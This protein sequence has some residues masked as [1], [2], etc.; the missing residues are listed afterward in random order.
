[1]LGIQLIEKELNPTG[2]FFGLWESRVGLFML[3]SMDPLVPLLPFCELTNEYFCSP[4]TC[5]KIY[6]PTRV[7]SLHFECTLLCVTREKIVFFILVSGAIWLRRSSP[8]ACMIY[9]EPAKRCINW[10]QATLPNRNQWKLSK[11]F[12]SHVP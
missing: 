9:L 7:K 12:L 8:I 3:V 6:P 1:M 11:A 2:I 5:R 10:R 4:L